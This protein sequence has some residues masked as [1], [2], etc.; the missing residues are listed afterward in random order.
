M[1]PLSSLECGQAFRRQPAEGFT[2]TGFFPTVVRRS[3]GVVSGTV[4]FEGKGESREAVMSRVADLFL[5]QDGLVVALPLPQDGAGVSVTVAA[6]KAVTVSANCLLT[7]CDSAD[8][9]PALLEPGAYESY[10]RILL[11][12]DDGSHVECF[13]GPWLVEIHE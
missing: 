2:L 3:E 11:N 9:A 12:Y 8:S 10:A 7:P 5:V 6:G 13:G 4:A 1:N